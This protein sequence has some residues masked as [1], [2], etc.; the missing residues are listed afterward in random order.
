M[1]CPSSGLHNIYRISGF[2]HNIKVKYIHLEDNG[3]GYGDRVNLLSG[4]A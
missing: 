4:V 2:L 1:P 3:V